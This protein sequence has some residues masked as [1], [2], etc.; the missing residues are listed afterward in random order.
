ML[1]CAFGACKIF[2]QKKKNKEFKTALITSFILLLITANLLTNK[3]QL[4]IHQTMRL[5]L[6][7]KKNLLG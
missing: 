1:F 2:L 7:E 3:V 4:I 5:K 6:L